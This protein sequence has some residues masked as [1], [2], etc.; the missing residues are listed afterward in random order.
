MTTLPRL[1]GLIAAFSVALACAQHSF[2]LTVE[3]LFSFG[4]PGAGPQG[5]LVETA[6]GDLIGVT[7]AGGKHRYVGVV[8]GNGTIFSIDPATGEQ[9]TLHHFDYETTGGFPKGGLIKG[10]DGNF[11]GTTS[12]GGG[13]V[14][15]SGD[16]G[17]VYRF[18]SGFAYS[19]LAHFDGTN[20][21]SPH[22]ALVEGPL[23][24]GERVFYGTTS[25][26]GANGKG[27]AFKVTTAGVLTVLH[28]FAGGANDG[29]QPMSGL[30]LAADGKFYGTT[31]RGGTNSLGT[32][33]SMELNGAVTV[34]HSFN[35]SDGEKPWAPLIQSSA[36]SLLYGVTQIGGANNEG[37]AF[38]ITTDGV[39]FTLLGSFSSSSTGSS[40]Y[41]RLLEVSPGT[42]MGLASSGFVSGASTGGTIYQLSSTA[43]SLQQLHEFDLAT[44]GGGAPGGLFKTSDDSLYGL[45]GSGPS[46]ASGSVFVTT[47]TGTVT[48]LHRFAPHDGLMPNG[49]LVEDSNGDLLG[50]TREG[51]DFGK[52]NV[53]KITKSGG[54]TVM[55]S[56]EGG[57]KGEVPIGELTIS[58][59]DYYGVTNRG[60]VAIDFFGNGGTIY[61]LTPGK[62][63]T[64]LHDFAG[65]YGDGEK[66]EAGL[67]DGQDG[68]L[69]GT[70]TAG[71]L[72]EPGNVGTI[73]KITTAGALTVIYAPTRGQHSP[74]TFDSPLTTDPLGGFFGTSASGG[75][76]IYGTLFH[77]TRAGAVTTLYNFDYLYAKVPKRGVVRDASGNL[78]GVTQFGG[79]NGDFAGTLYRYGEDGTFTILHH[80]SEGSG[81]GP[82]GRLAF[83]PDGALYGTC[84]GGVYSRG[85]I[86]KCTTSGQYI[87]LHHFNDDEGSAVAGGL[88]LASDNKFYG[89]AIEGGDQGAGTVFRFDPMEPIANEPPIAENDM[90]LMGA[91]AAPVTINVLANDHDPEL[92]P[93]TVVDTAQIPSS[94]FG[95]VAISADGKT[96]TYTPNP[97]K[98]FPEFLGYDEF[99]YT[100][101]D[102]QGGVSA[103]VVRIRQLS[104][105]AS[106]YTDLLRD[107]GTGEPV[108]FLRVKITNGG[109]VSGRLI[110]LGG[111]YG[112]GG[113]L[114]VNGHANL[115]I[116]RRNQGSWF[117]RF[118]LGTGGLIR[119]HGLVDTDGTD[120][121]FHPL[122]TQLVA[123]DL[124]PRIGTY[125][126]LLSP[127]ASTA[128]DA[129]KPQGTGYGKLVIGK[130][131]TVK[132]VA[133]TGDDTKFSVGS[134]IRGDSTILVYTDLYKKP[135]GR[136]VGQLT[137]ERYAL[138][139]R[140]VGTLEWTK[141]KQDKQPDPLY[142][143]GF[144]T[145]TTDFDA[146]FYFAPVKAPAAFD[147]TGA[148]NFR[149]MQELDDSNGAATLTLTGD[150]I[151]PLVP[152]INLTID[153]KNKAT[154]PLP[155][156]VKSFSLTPNSGLFKATLLT[157]LQP[158]GKPIIV[159]GII[160]QSQARGNGLFFNGATTGSAVFE[161]KP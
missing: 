43:G 151:T 90:V 139:R 33:Y 116:K 12:G 14:G 61:K 101:R 112:F 127:A 25:S 122:R 160:N 67:I 10:S 63:H 138:D 35:G 91:K 40:P 29:E 119:I 123:G 144:P 58:G 84:G 78:Y 11:Y 6:D 125:N 1:R 18:T 5:E 87:V 136:L 143:N 79:E 121:D 55:H 107:P 74:D 50:V 81:A 51:G 73:F 104:T 92:D 155:A 135:K 76:G 65:E 2:A 42:F 56:F 130:T 20:G 131:G 129:T 41:G 49:G 137:F 17:V 124:T 34:L 93:L 53:Y 147:P 109:S 146:S 85:C 102:S 141:P 161:A 103:A 113:K 62:V 7:T 52:G 132:I 110:L 13:L 133:R 94:A 27:T 148:S 70:T 149:V 158:N 145:I 68:F 77:V 39:T 153:T 21:A 38:K 157:P 97:P 126:A 105:F 142:P 86:F 28:H 31:Y 57:A 159:N 134:G 60:G 89:V 64:V 111:S 128:G 69:Y 30:C 75:T 3:T 154:P 45:L 47:P 4:Y 114:D 118:D 72:V 26:G 82:R 54:L 48:L 16:R 32:V 8:S 88:L 150:G 106:E 100:I 19:V 44:E 83:G 46:T 59:G 108:G 120:Y 9:T 152:A 99:R 15:S 22:G 98:T 156:S 71:G 80:F 37:A 96:I 23:D 115:E 140:V 66:P 117:V 95:T 24:G 36:D